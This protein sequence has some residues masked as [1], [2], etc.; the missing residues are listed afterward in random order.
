LLATALEEGCASFMAWTVTGVDP[1]RAANPYGMAHEHELWVEF[2]REMNGTD[3]SNWLYNGD[4][5]KDRPADLG[6]FVGARICGAYYE[7]AAD[8]RRAVKEIF[9][10]PDPAAFLARSGY[11]P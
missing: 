7:R 1:A 5:S 3:A 2:Q 4:R 10:M 6:Y 11:A 8:K 9:A